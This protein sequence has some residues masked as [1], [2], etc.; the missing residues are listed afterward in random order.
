MNVSFF[1]CAVLH[2]AHF[3][4]PMPENMPYV[5]AARAVRAAVPSMTFARMVRT[6]ES[7]KAD[8]NISTDA[9][10]RAVRAVELQGA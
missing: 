8:L 5:V 1:T 6:A 2:L 4:Q 9:A 10:A 7:L 3:N